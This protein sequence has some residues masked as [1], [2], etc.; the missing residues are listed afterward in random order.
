MILFR[1]CRQ[2]LNSLSNS[3]STIS[4]NFITSKLIFDRHTENP[5]KKFT[6]M[7]INDDKF[8]HQQQCMPNLNHLEEV[9]TDSVYRKGKKSIYDCENESWCTEDK[10][11]DR[12]D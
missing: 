3:N 12:E 2:I 8:F 4:R 6:S 7:I 10:F 1:N 9:Y 11:N 5:D